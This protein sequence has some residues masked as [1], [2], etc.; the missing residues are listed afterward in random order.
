LKGGLGQG[1]EIPTVVDLSPGR[2]LH[3]CCCRLKR[4]LVKAF[5][6]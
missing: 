6:C 3:R 2:L 1:G 5:V 4:V